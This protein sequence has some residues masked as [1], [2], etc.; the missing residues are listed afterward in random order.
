M[1]EKYAMNKIFLSI[2]VMF[3]ILFAT[4]NTRDIVRNIPII[5]KGKSIGKI[6]NF[7]RYHALLIYVEKYQYLNNLKTPKNDVEALAKV[8]RNRYG[9]NHIKIVR[10]PRNSDEL[11]EILDTFQNKLKK[12]DNL[13]IY[14]AGHGSKEG[15]W[16][17]GNAKRHSR[18]GWIPLKQAVNYTLN[19]MR[20]KHILVVADSCY[21]G[22][23]TRG[24]G[25]LSYL[26]PDDIKYYSKLYQIKSRNVLTAGGLQPVLDSD[27]NNPNH[28]V[29]ANGFLHM[30]KNNRKSIFSLDEQY[31]KIKKYV[32]LNTEDQS[33]LY[34]D[35]KQT[36]HQDGG[37]FIFIDHKVLGNKMNIFSYEEKE[38]HIIEK[39]ESNYK[40][41]NSKY[42]LTIH[43]IPSNSRVQ[44]LNIKPKYYDGIALKQGTFKIKVS[45]EG[46]ESRVFSMVLREDS[47]RTVQLNKNIVQTYTKLPISNKIV[48]P[49]FSKQR[50]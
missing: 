16:Q 37:D 22:I 25:T 36:G 34:S 27:I 48:V 2:F 28:S 38:S 5:V 24:G 18:V 7:G 47:I 32:Q 10:N 12:E 21:A 1:G 41:K 42:K 50:S 26:T 40:P 43:T 46:Y 49:T 30:L 8:L 4:S 23:L 20:S 17:L 11:I 3:N 14:Y 19:K 6:G 45:K 15:F 35:V 13:L 44:I 9:F 39:V 33:P 29:F 31:Y